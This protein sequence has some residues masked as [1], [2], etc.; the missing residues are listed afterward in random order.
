M[1]M[2]EFMN[3]LVWVV[4]AFALIALF[5]GCGNA[6]EA[7]QERALESA[8]AAQGNDVDIDID[9]DALTVTSQDGA[10]SVTT[11]ENVSLPAGFPKDVPIYPGAQVRAAVQD[12][13]SNGYHAQLHTADAVDKVAEYYTKEV[14]S[15]GWVED[16]VVK[17]AGG[18]P[19]QVLNYTQDE[20]TLNIMILG[21]GQGSSI[22]VATQ[23]PPQ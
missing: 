23:A 9:G 2:E 5:L 3:R 4:S 13:G 16:S 18:Q 17:Q 7:A 6:K 22:T 11:G 1:S 20:R 21:E 15:H 8:A 14:E 19:M 10:V 12:A